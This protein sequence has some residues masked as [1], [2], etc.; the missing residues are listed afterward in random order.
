MKLIKLA[1]LTLIIVS[2]TKKY[3][4]YYVIDKYNF[5]KD[6]YQPPITKKLIAKREQQ[7]REYCE[8]QI[9]FSSNA[10]VATDKAV[11]GL[12][13]SMC[14]ESQYL[15]NNKVTETWWTTIVY[16][17]SCVKIESYCGVKKP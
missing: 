13:Q 3:Q 12:A 16:S 5:N 6:N 8:G 9:L 15:L 17:R 14:G 7:S 1:L 4:T 2:C 10:K 11:S